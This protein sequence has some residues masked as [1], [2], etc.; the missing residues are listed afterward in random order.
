V[1]DPFFL[2]TLTGS[3]LSTQAFNG[4]YADVGGLSF[5]VDAGAMYQFAAYLTWQGSATTVG[6]NPA[7]GGTCTFTY[8]GATFN[9]GKST[10]GSSWVQ[11]HAGRQ[12]GTGPA[13]N[14]AAQATTNYSITATGF[15]IVNAGGTMTICAKGV[16]TAGTFT[17][18]AGSRFLL[19]QIP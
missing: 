6:I 11:T 19:W 17:I 1:A 7:L 9:I 13:T 8:V 14:V 5:S 10:D 16:G 3:A 15:V 18:A 4:A 12:P 2:G